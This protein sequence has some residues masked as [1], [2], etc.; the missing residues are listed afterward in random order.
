MACKFATGHRPF[1]FRILSILLG[2]F[3]PLSSSPVHI[4]RLLS[5]LRSKGNDIEKFSFISFLRSADEVFFS[6]RAYEVATL[7]HP[8]AIGEV[9]LGQSK[10]FVRAEGLFVA[11]HGKGKIASSFETNSVSA[12]LSI[13]LDLVTD[14]QALLGDPLYLGLR[15]QRSSEAEMEE[16]IDEFFMEMALMFPRHWCKLED[17]SSGRA[18]SYSSRFCPRLPLIDD[19][20]QCIGAVV[21]AGLLS[22][23]LLLPLAPKDRWFLFYGTDSD[24]VGVAKQARSRIWLVDSKGILYQGREGVTDYEKCFARRDYAGQPTTSSFSDIARFI[25]PTAL[26]GLFYSLRTSGGSVIFASVSHFQGRTFGACKWEPGQANNTYILP[27]LA[28]STILCRAS[29]V[30]GSMVV[31]S[32]LGLTKSRIRDI[33]AHVAAHVIRAAQAAG[34]DRFTDLRRMTD[35]PLPEFVR[36][37]M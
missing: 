22:A 5:Q 9:C 34:V 32:V 37:K 11:V 25:K 8:P 7:T 20:V 16:F 19:D 21:L 14:N 23:A 36:R 24:G 12:I 13:I 1:Q 18:F 30:T 4:Q 29:S 3:H 17:F 35:T 33:N 28:L 27:G 15:Q 31:A 2:F 6:P 10:D 26:I